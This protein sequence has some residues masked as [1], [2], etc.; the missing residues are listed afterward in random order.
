VSRPRLPALVLLAALSPAGAAP[1]GAIPDPLSLEQALEYAVAHPRVTLG[2][3]ASDLPRSPPLYLDCER[4][5][6]SQLAGDDSRAR[7]SDALLAPES[8]Q[9]LEIM[10][11]FLDVL[12]A[13]LSHARFNEAMAVAYIQYDRANTRRELGQFAE[14]LVAELET[15]YQDVLRKRAASEA[16]QRLTRALLAQ[17]MGRPG[18]LPRELTPPALALPPAGLP[19]L[20]T[21]VAEAAARPRPAAGGAPDAPEQADARRRLLDMELRR[22]VLEL[23]LRLEILATG[24]RYAETESF[25]RDLKLDESRTLYEQEV[26]ADLG[27]SMSR[28]TMARMQEAQIRYCRALAWAELSALRGAP[29][30]PAPHQEPPPET[31]P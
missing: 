6:F 7:P 10:E 25:L 1:G 9:R 26:K 20:E 8:A 22:Q 27:Y 18:E 3:G 13:D 12:L 23:L 17:A 24:A 29:V 16:S 2:E 30:P 4:L 28:Q 15:E 31:S 14:V 19:E 11:R 5:A 21:V